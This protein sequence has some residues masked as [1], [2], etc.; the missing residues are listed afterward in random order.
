MRLQILILMLLI[1]DSF[2]GGRV[3]L[4]LVYLFLTQLREFYF[5]ENQLYVLQEQWYQLALFRPVLCDSGLIS[6]PERN[7]FSLWAGEMGA[8]QGRGGCIFS[9]C[10][11]KLDIMDFIE[12]TDNSFLSSCF[13]RVLVH[14]AYSVYL[15][16]PIPFS[17]KGSFVFPGDRASF[18]VRF[19]YLIHY[20]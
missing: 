9:R 17:M 6:C 11:C 13:I 12:M 2:W 4:L 10:F 19:S 1:T 18:S 3:P 14:S 15:Q 5:Q 20:Q 16:L 7:Q 8:R